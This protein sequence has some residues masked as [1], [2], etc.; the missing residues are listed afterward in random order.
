LVHHGAVIVFDVVAIVEPSFLAWIDVT[1]IF[2]PE[3]VPAIVVIQSDDRL[4]ETVVV[5]D[6]FFEALLEIAVLV[7]LPA[8]LGFVG[9]QEITRQFL[10]LERLEVFLYHEREQEDH[11][12]AKEDAI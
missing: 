7:P 10:G 5:G 6:V 2:L 1:H 4:A 8:E 9:L 11:Q 3:K 12:E